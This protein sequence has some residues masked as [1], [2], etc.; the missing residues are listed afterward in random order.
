MTMR[1]VYPSG[2]L[3]VLLDLD[4]AFHGIV[5]EINCFGNVM[6]DIVDHRALK[7]R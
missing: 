5:D 1:R 6:I 2:S 3:F 7:R 4:H